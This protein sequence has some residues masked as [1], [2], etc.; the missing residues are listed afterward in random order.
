MALTTRHAAAC[1]A[2]GEMALGLI[3][4]SIAGGLYGLR[5]ARHALRLASQYHSRLFELERTVRE[6]D[7]EIVARRAVGPPLILDEWGPVGTIPSLAD[8][9]ARHK[10]LPTLTP[11][12]LDHARAYNPLPTVADARGDAPDLR[13]DR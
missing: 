8:H 3:G 5:H 7:A 9:L 12:A 2:V 11:T 6:K 10:G 1:G 13:P 4:G